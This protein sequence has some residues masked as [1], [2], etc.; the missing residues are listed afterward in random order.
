VGAVL[1]LPTGSTNG[2]SGTWSPAANNQTTTTYTFTPSLIEVSNNCPAPVQ[3][4]VIVD[5]FVDPVF[6]PID[7]ICQGNTLT[8]PTLSL[9]GINGTWSPAE[10]NQA[11]TTYTFT[12]TDPG[13]IS[14]A[15]M[16]VPVFPLVTPTFS[17]PDSLCQNDSTSFPTI[18]DNGISGTWSPAFDSQNTTTY[19]FTPD[20]NECAIAVQHTIEVAPRI[21]PSFLSLSDT[22]C[23]GS[24]LNF[25]IVSD[26]N[27]SGSWSPALNNQQT[28]TYTFTRDSNEC[29]TSIDFTLTV[30]PLAVTFDTITRCANELPFVWNG[31]SLSSTT[32]TSA[33]LQDQFGCDSTANL[34]FEVLP[35]K[36]SS[37]S[38]EICENEPP[39]VW[40]GQSYDQ[41]GT[42]QRVF[43]AQNGCDSTVTFD[44]TVNPAPE[45][46][47]SVQPWS[48]C[49]PLEIEV[50][51]DASVHNSANTSTYLW[52]F[53]NGQT[54]TTASQAT[55]NYTSDGCYDVSL[56][57]TN[58]FG[59]IKTEQLTDAV[60]IDPNPV[61]DFLPQNNPLPLVDPTTL[62]ENNST[63]ASTFLWD[64]GDGTQ[65][66]SEF[67][68]IHTYPDQAGNY[69]TS[70]S[71][72][73]ANG[74]RDSVQEFITVEQDPI[75][76]V[77]NAFTPDG[78][79]FNETFSPVFA[80]N[81][82]LSEYSFKIYNRWGE[83]LFESKDP[84]VGW[85]GTYGGKIVQDGTYVYT[86]DFQEQGFDER[87]QQNGSVVLL[88]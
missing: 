74:C 8:L 47:L 23:A 22:L 83:I 39:F 45:I 32:N 72:E 7:S 18:S 36:T 24:S 76:Y 40:A 48:G 20:S 73:N 27:I 68:P 46:S 58:E 14:S 62:L 61:A 85:D 1:N 4:T 33:T 56:T 43:T 30:L 60:C 25:P 28:T 41:T 82:E 10:N 26:N 29:A 51:N 70:L 84:A 3:E 31:Q 86:L 66:S 16:T 19:T 75:F 17:L 88:R 35:V 2:F 6:T 13:C 53:G 42:Y 38:A 78:N 80:D 79:Q 87:F 21:T 44:L 12:P 59:C 64:F 69:L 67:S 50:V 71:I 15:Q 57:I 77:P 63:S 49:L 52:D 34:Y 55:A 5:P 37:F 81:L 65:N 11:T 9:N 54:A